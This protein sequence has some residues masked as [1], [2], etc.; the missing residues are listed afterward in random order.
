MR[1]IEPGQHISLMRPPVEAGAHGCLWGPFLACYHHIPKTEHPQATDLVPDSHIESGAALDILSLGSGMPAT[2]GCFQL[3]R[4]RET[5]SREGMKRDRVLSQKKSSD[6]S[7]L[8]QPAP[9][10]AGTR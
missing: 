3:E 8:G 6:F 2:Q 1:E 10:A 7:I 5:S 4:I 9:Q